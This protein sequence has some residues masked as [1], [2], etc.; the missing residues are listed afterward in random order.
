MN[1]LEQELKETR[2]RLQVTID[3]YETALEELKS[4]NQELQSVNHELAAKVDE[5]ERS[6]PDLRNLFESTQIASVFL[7]RFMIIRSYTPAVTSIFNLIAGDRGR[8][9]TNIAN[10]LEGVDLQ[11]DIRQA[12]DERKMLERPVR[13]RNGKVCHL[14]RVLPYRTADDEI[15]GVLITFV[16]VTAVVAAFEEQQRVLVAELNHRVRNMLQVVIGL[17]N[18]TLH[19]SE[20]LRQFEKSFMGRMQAL[21]RAYELLSRDGWKNVS[22]SGLLHSQL[23]PFASEGSHYTVEGD[24]LELTPSAALAMGMVLYELATNAVKYGALSV[25]GGHLHISWQTSGAGESGKDLV[26]HWRE[27]GGPTVHAPARHGFGSEL[28][29]RQ[30]SYELNGQAAM[31]FREDGLQVTLRL[32]TAGAVVNRDGGTGQ[33]PS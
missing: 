16:N 9:I 12:F 13:L 7:D 28:M 25:P 27:S 4:G 19:S 11:A 5:L 3:E 21:A 1:S 31:E 30:L 26:F 14:M 17:S 10:Q 2:D 6:N 8:P 29:Q 33:R 24:G 32:P 15:D 20:N 23:S 22:I 18:Q